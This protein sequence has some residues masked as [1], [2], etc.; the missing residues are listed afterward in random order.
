MTLKDIA[1]LSGVSPSTV[2]RILNDKYTKAAGSEVKERVWK[3]VRD[4]GYTPNSNAK[5]LRSSKSSKNGVHTGEAAK[6]YFACVYARNSDSGDM[7]FSELSKAIEFEAYKK[8]YILKCSFYTGELDGADLKSTLKSEEIKGIAVL[9]RFT[10]DTVAAMVG[11]QKNVVY[12]GL[13]P[14]ET[15]HDTVFCDGY[16]AGV[17]AVSEL[18]RLNHKSIAYI[19]ETLKENRYRGY[20]DTLKNNDI[21]LNPNLIIESPQ[22]LV[23]GYQGAQRLIESNLNFS[24]VFC[25][26]DATAMGCIKYL[27]ENKIKVPEEVSVISI[28]DIEMSRYYMPMLTT[29]HIP[30]SELGSQTAKLLTDKIE[31][32][33]TLPVKMELPFSLSRRDSCVAFSG[34]YFNEK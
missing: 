34:K 20:Q 33:H 15:N 4:T 12:V 25:A 10:N 29:I 18:I 9:G 2:S 7:F 24:A 17:S 16:K 5:V 32:G 26:N 13:N 6:K 1:R 30:I 31:N 3:I 22:T 28:D 19:G 27:N 8:G 23:G 14:S 21:E 11:S